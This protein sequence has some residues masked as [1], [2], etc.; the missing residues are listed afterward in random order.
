LTGN[1]AGIVERMHEGEASL[2]LNFPGLRLR[3]IECVA[4]DDH[5]TAQSS[6]GFD[7]DCRRSSRHDDRCRNPEFAGRQRYTLRMIACGRA[8]DAL[9]SLRRGQSDDLVVRAAKLE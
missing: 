3:V 4:M 2:G 5:V 9:L 1:Y 6:H 8:D 7:L